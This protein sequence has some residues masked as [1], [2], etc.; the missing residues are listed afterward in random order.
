MTELSNFSDEQLKA[1]LEQREAE[2]KFAAYTARA[3]RNTRIFENKELLLSLMDHGRT[4]CSDESPT[5]G[6]AHNGYYRC[7][8]CALI[9]TDGHDLGDVEMELGFTI[10]PV[11]E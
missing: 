10:K 11:S 6:Y 3:A 1:E 8:K 7:Y 2:K 4:S 5:N 9:L